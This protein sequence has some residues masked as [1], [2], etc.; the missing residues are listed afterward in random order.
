MSVFLKCV[1]SLL[2]DLDGKGVQVVEHHMVLV[3][4]AGLGHTVKRRRGN[5]LGKVSAF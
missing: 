3:Q 1:G 2:P 4:A 5:K